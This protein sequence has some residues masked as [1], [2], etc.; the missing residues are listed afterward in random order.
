MLTVGRDMRLSSIDYRDALAK[1][2][3]STGCDVIDIGMVPTPVSYF[4]LYHLNPDGGVMITGSHNPSNF[5][6]FKISLGKHSL[7]GK[8]IQEL[9]AM[10]ESNDF[11]TGQGTLTEQH[12]QEEYLI[13]IVFPLASFCRG[14]KQF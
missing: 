7:F 12:V 3:M 8:Q 2:L 10:I 11:E 9:R 4:S 6:G 13:G 5:N 14:Q 1:G